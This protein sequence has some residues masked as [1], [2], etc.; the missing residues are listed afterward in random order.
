MI[1]KSFDSFHGIK[2]QSLVASFSGKVIQCGINNRKYLN[3]EVLSK[4]WLITEWIKD[5]GR[6][7]NNVTYFFFFPKFKVI[8][9][10]FDDFLFILKKKFFLCLV[11]FFF[12]KLARKK[13]LIVNKRRGV[14]FVILSKNKTRERKKSIFIISRIFSAI[15]PFFA[16]KKKY[17]NKSIL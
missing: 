16:K 2:Y 17:L 8:P 14:C 9:I 7:N 11:Y 3:C 15:I 4:S 5:N 10:D 6:A 12:F 13:K 1:K